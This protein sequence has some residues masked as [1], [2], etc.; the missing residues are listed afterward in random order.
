MEGVDHGVLQ[1]TKSN[2]LS[3]EIVGSQL[4]FSANNAGIAPPPVE[5]LC[6]CQSLSTKALIHN[7]LP[8]P[9]ILEGSTNYGMD[10]S[11]IPPPSKYGES[12]SNLIPF[13]V[14][15]GGLRGNVK[16]VYASMKITGT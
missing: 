8:E 14:C 5:G 12:P 10:S 1:N 3:Q 7:W 4:N 16:C 11:K 2:N 15:G 13:Q 6:Y 9:G